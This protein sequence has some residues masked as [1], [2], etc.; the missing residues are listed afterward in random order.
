VARCTGKLRN[1]LHKASAL[2]SVCGRQDYEA[3][4]GDRCTWPAL[5][6]QEK[7]YRHVKKSWWYVDAAFRGQAWVLHSSNNNYHVKQLVGATLTAKEVK[8][9]KRMALRDLAEAEHYWETNHAES[10]EILRKEQQ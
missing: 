7:A 1:T 5:T 2:C 9:H 10:I 4:E 6:E 8:Y 3:N